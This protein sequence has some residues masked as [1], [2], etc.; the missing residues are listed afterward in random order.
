[1]SNYLKKNAKLGQQQ[2]SMRTTTRAFLDSWRIDFEINWWA[3]NTVNTM[4]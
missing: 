4:E 2:N 3:E 1:M